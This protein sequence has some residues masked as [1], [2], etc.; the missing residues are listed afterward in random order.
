MVIRRRF[1]I[2]ETCR[3]LIPNNDQQ[4]R[5]FVI[6]PDIV[7]DCFFLVLISI[8]F[9]VAG[10]FVGRHDFVIKCSIFAG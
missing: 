10:D 3:L 4:Q 6:K 1:V 8:Y 5:H 9:A 2:L 7:Y